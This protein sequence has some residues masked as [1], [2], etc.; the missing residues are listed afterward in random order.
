MAKATVNKSN[1]VSNIV[2][3]VIIGLF[4]ITAII[5]M[6]GAIAAGSYADAAFAGFGSLFVL[7]MAGLLGGELRS[8]VS[9][10]ATAA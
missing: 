9:T 3:A 2:L 8:M 5:L 4:V 10:K 1:K 7:Y 6:F